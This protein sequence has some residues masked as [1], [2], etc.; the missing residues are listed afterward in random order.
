MHATSTPALTPSPP[1][2]RGTAS[3][4]TAMDRD[5]CDQYVRLLCRFAP[6]DVLPFLL[7]HD[8]Y[9]LPACLDACR[10]HRVKGAVTYLL[11]RMGDV[12]GATRLAGEDVAASIAALAEAVTG[13][14]VDAA[15]ERAAGAAAGVGPRGG[16][17]AVV[18]RGARPWEYRDLLSAGERGGWEYREW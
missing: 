15:A 3:E 18:Q 6:F 12:E 11:E 8:A 4:S 14:E 1:L 7:S 10:A 5:T 2:H 9:S 16:A 13:G 17:G